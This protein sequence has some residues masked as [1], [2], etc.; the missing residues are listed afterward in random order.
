M[1]GY[2]RP[3]INTIQRAR[4]ISGFDIILLWARRIPRDWKSQS[5]TSFWF[6]SGFTVDTGGREF[7]QS[8]CR[9]CC[10]YRCPEVRLHTA[11]LGY[12]R[13]WNDRGDARIYERPSNGH[14]WFLSL[15][16]L[17]YF[18]VPIYDKYP[19]PS[20]LVLKLEFPWYQRHHLDE[21][22]PSFK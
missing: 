8:S 1:G 22:I 19:L 7:D 4:R 5:S 12:L 2:L 9:C 17:Y 16:D 13:L 20:L 11:D 10:L 15:P 18:R 21:G 14:W 3:P 6:V